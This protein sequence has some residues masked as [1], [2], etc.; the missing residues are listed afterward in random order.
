M[1]T[2]SF[3][4][5]CLIQ[6]GNRRYFTVSVSIHSHGLVQYFFKSSFI[7]YLILILIS[8]L[9][10]KYL[11][12]GQETESVHF[13]GKPKINYKPTQLLLY[14]QWFIFIKGANI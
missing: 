8:K 14:Y 1:P 7:V 13:F 10:V 6:T 9:A 3:H 12:P 5:N 4:N 11:V 2:V